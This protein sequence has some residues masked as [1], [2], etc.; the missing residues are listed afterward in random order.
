MS[1]AVVAVLIIV[2]VCAVGSYAQ[3]RKRTKK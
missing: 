2:F 1:G 3:R